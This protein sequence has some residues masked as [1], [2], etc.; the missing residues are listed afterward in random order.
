M[1]TVAIMQP[2]FFPYIGYWQLIDSADLFVIYDDVNYINRGWVN[3]NRILSQGKTVY[4]TAP[5]Q[6][7]SQNRRICDLNLHPSPV[8]RTKLIKTLLSTYR[9]APHFSGVFPVV[10]QLILHNAPN[11][12]DYLANQLCI[13][14]A[15][16]GINTEIVQTSRIYRNDSLSGQD[17]IL[18]ICKKEGATT[19]INP[20]GGQPLY[21]AT[22]FN[23]EGVMLQFIAMRAVPYQQGAP[24]FVPFLSIIDVLMATGV[25]GTRQHLD[26]SDLITPPETY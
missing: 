7:A 21:N 15:F 22:A 4:A 9:K 2:Y 19:Y 25:V 13:L 12:S 20:I 16:M 14:S 18:D 23:K 6:Q 24:V 5:L 1:K 11:L 3:R 8:W 26:S 17:R 10:E